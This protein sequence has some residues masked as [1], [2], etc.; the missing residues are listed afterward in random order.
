MRNP[1]C[2]K[3]ELCHKSKKVCL[4]GQGSSSTLMLISG[5]ATYTDTFRGYPFAGEEGDLLDHI[6][7]KLG[8]NREQLY[9]TSLLKCSPPKGGLPKSKAVE[10]LVGQCFPYLQEEIMQVRPKVL[11][12]MGS[13]AV[14]FIGGVNF[15]TRAEGYPLDKDATAFGIPV[16][17]CFHPSAALQAPGFEKNVAAALAK[18]CKLAGIETTPTGQGTI[19][20]YKDIGGLE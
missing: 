11:V 1:L 10:V 6:L 17:P 13:L 19:Y 20:N 14:K 3:C 15:V 12:P 7:F 4:W 18:A 8:L 16:V 9:L 5:N 2:R